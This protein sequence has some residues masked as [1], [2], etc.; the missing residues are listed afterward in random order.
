MTCSLL[1]LQLLLNSIINA[2]ESLSSLQLALLEQ[3]TQKMSCCIDS[4][5]IN[6]T[7]Q[8]WLALSS[9]PLFWQNISFI[10][11]NTACE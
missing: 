3:A 5:H 10:V 7:N 6:H 4:D 2:E 8:I 1:D 9:S 11:V